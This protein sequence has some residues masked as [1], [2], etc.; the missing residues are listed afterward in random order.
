MMMLTQVGSQEE[1][2]DDEGAAVYLVQLR[3]AG[4][5][6]RLVASQSRESHLS[7]MEMMDGLL[8]PRDSA[9]YQHEQ[10]LLLTRQHTHT[11]QAG[12][13]S[14]PTNTHHWLLL[15]VRLLTLVHYLLTITAAATD[16]KNTYTYIYYYDTCHTLLLLLYKDFVKNYYCDLIRW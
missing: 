10:P 11:L 8:S 14:A 16:N 7:L 5:G 13:H 6:R 1:H 2:D 15:L 9:L 3:P 12:S 4:P